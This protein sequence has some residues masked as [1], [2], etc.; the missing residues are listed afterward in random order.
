MTKGKEGKKKVDLRILFSFNVSVDISLLLSLVFIIQV[1]KGSHTLRTA[2]HF[3]AH[4][5]QSKSLWQISNFP[6]T[7]MAFG[8]TDHGQ[9]M[10]CRRSVCGGLPI[11]TD[12]SCNVSS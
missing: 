4:I 7:V 1:D 11:L 3:A 6:A 12:H 5:D 9:F 10:T 8:S 2:S